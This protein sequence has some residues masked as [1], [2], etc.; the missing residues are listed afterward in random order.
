[1]VINGLGRIGKLT[2][3]Y[4]LQENYFDSFVINIGRPVGKSLQNIAN[5]IGADSTYG[6]IEKFLFG[7]KAERDTKI[8]DEEEILLEIFVKPVI[9]L[10]ET[11]NSKNIDW[12]EYGGKLAIDTTGA[13][14]DPTIAEDSEKVSLWGHLS[15]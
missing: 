4:Q 1:M 12:R 6:S 5:L 7:I 3:W 13:F 2:L 8:I 11:R 14:N 15:A 10:C 9:I